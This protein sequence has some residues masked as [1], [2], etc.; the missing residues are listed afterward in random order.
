MG[1]GFRV[2]RLMGL[3][4][5]GLGFMG[6]WVS[7]LGCLLALVL[8]VFST[9]LIDSMEANLLVVTNINP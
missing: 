1:L 9:P 7:G 8:L 4:V 5:S 6:L 2:Y 3:W